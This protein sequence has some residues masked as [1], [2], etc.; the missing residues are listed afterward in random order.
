LCVAEQKKRDAFVDEAMR[1]A[2]AMREL[3]ELE[4]DGKHADESSIEY[5]ERARAA[6]AAY[7]K[8]TR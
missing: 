1:L 2:D 4:A 6:L 8:G 3:L 5:W 7:L